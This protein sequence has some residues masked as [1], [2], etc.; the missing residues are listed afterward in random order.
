MAYFLRY[1]R[2]KRIRK[3]QWAQ[4]QAFLKSMNDARVKA[5]RHVPS[6]IQASRDTYAERSRARKIEVITRMR[7]NAATQ[8]QSVFRGHKDRK[9]VLE[10]HRRR[11]IGAFKMQ[12]SFRTF[13]SRQIANR[14]RQRRRRFSTLLRSSRRRSATT[15]SRN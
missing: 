15:S 5:L 1:W 3:V 10:L 8:L 9:M 14:E 12:G 11:Y 7:N 4:R 6:M 2:A 13:K